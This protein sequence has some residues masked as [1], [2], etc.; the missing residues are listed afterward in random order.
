MDI[1]ELDWVLADGGWGRTAEIKSH[2]DLRVWTGAMDMA[3]TIYELAKTS[4]LRRNIA[5]RHK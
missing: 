5:L 1:G 2:R 4:R 3:Q